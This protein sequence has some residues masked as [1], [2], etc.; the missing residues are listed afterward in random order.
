MLRIGAEA[1]SVVRT[2]TAEQA[3]AVWAYGEITSSR[4]GKRYRRAAPAHIV[5]LAES[6]EPFA[7]L[8]H[9]DQAALVETLLACRSPKLVANLDRSKRYR[10][11]QLSRRELLALWA[12]PVFDRLA[13]GRIVP[14]RDF[15]RDPP[16]LGADGTV[17]RRDPGHAAR[18]VQSDIFRQRNPGIII[19]VSRRPVLIEGYLRSLLFLRD[20]NASAFDV[21]WPSDLGH[22]ADQKQ[23]RQCPRWAFPIDQSSTRR[24]LAT[25]GKGMPQTIAF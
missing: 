11:I 4:R 1:F 23:D 5:K 13:G 24:T 6:A 10:R 15:L 12:L 3:K 9:A 18:S 17:N 21:W 7:C 2:I 22:P 16:M 20:R 14:Y 25:S 8:P 19:N